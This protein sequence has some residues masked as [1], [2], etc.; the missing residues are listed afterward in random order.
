MTDKPIRFICPVGHVMLMPKQ[1]D[2][3]LL[4]MECP[5]CGKRVEFKREVDDGERT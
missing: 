3:K 1:F 4:I 5:Q 2:C